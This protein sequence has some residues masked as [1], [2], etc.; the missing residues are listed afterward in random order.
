MVSTV[1]TSTV[2]TVSTVSTTSV[3]QMSATFGLM[4]IILLIAFLAAKELV[5]ARRGQRRDAIARSLNV[6]IVPFILVFSLIMA[7]NIFVSLL[8]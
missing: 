5:G 3:M 7:V 1:T 6:G 4:V 2:S 8:G